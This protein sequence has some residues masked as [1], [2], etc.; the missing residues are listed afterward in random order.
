MRSL[1]PC[2]LC[3]V[4]LSGSAGAAPPGAEEPKSNPAAIEKALVAWQKK[5]YDGALRQLQQALKSAKDEDLAAYTAVCTDKAG[6]PL[7]AVIHT[8]I[9]TCAVCSGHHF[10]SCRACKGRGEIVGMRG[11][12]RCDYCFGTGKIFCKACQYRYNSRAF[13]D[14]L[15]RVVKVTGESP[16]AA[17]PAA[18]PAEGRAAEEQVAELLSQL[19][20]RENAVALEAI[21]KLAG[22][23]DDP[24]VAAALTALAKTEKSMERRKALA[25]GLGAALS[26]P[27]LR[28]LADMATLDGAVEVR[29]AACTALGGSG[30][31][32]TVPVLVAVLQQEKGNLVRVAAVTAL[33]SLADPGS[34]PI[35]C[36]ALGDPEVGVRLAALA[37]VGRFA[38][39]DSLAPVLARAVSP[40][41]RMRASVARLLRDYEPTQE[42]QLALLKLLGDELPQARLEAINSV[43]AVGDE[44]FEA[45]LEGMAAADVD[46]ECRAAAAAALKAVRA[47]GK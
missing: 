34:L 45:R 35:V 40:N 20:A 13:K 17:P 37:A 26:P 4:L 8:A 29:V 12:Y 42:V 21:R 28:L 16:T 44:R 11:T 3:V 33:G 1:L 14:M 43:N 25:E 46:G 39:T 30:D 6:V 19:S 22:M 2:I 31:K 24:K 41:A 23:M 32:T 18:K 5:D 36:D 9:E 15:A 47:R 7:A 10:E 27:G 38:R